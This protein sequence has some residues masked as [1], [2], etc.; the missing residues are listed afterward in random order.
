MLISIDPGLRAC[1]VA[2]WR[3]TGELERA[4]YVLGAKAAPGAVAWI[5]MA[6]AIYHATEIYEPK[7]LVI[8]LPRT[9]GGRAA[10]GDAN[11]LIQLAATVGAITTRLRLPTTVYLPDH[12]KGQTTK[13]VTKNRVEERLSPAE[14]ARIIWPAPS[15]RH[16]V[17]DGIALGMFHLR[18]S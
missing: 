3:P 17:I 12:W 1:G 11:D 18:R 2:I 8:E 5:A 4:E 6:T 9:Y 10:R 16:N 15:L 13:E 7:G 14:H